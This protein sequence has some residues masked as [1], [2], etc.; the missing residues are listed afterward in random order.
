MTRYSPRHIILLSRWPSSFVREGTVHTAMQLD[1]CLL[2]QALG[3]SFGS[4][5]LVQDKRETAKP[6]TPHTSAPWES[7][8]LLAQDLISA[9]A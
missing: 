2:N 6:C 8:V 9:H 7:Y 3:L 1:H 4:F 5:A